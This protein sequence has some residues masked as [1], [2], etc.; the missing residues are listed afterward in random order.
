MET[1]K[2]TELLKDYKIEFYWMNDKNGNASI[3]YKKPDEFGKKEI[4]NIILFYDAAPDS[5]EQ[6][7][8]WGGKC[9]LFGEHFKNNLIDGIMEV[10]KKIVSPKAL[11]IKFYRTDWRGSEFRESGEIFENINL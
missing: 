11:L 10:I 2:I 5:G 4:G 1:K 7:P 3:W 6:A 8:H 9:F